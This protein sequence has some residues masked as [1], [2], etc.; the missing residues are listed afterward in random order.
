MNSLSV[1]HPPSLTRRGALWWVAATL[2]LRWGN[3]WATVC[4]EPSQ[5][6]EV[7][8]TNCGSIDGRE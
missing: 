6:V 4:S 8:E 1:D 2:P 3:A 5:L 7:R